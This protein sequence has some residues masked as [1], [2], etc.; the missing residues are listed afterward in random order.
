MHTK[1]PRSLI[2]SP[3]ALDVLVAVYVLRKYPQSPPTST[4]TCSL[5]P[6]WVY[7]VVPKSW[8]RD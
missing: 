2:G 4:S 1:F 5:F 6:V 8:T 3:P 7:E